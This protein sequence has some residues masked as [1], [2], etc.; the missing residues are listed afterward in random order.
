MLEAVCVILDKDNVPSAQTGRLGVVQAGEGFA[1]PQ[2]LT[3]R[4]FLCFLS[5]SAS[6]RRF[7]AVA[8]TVY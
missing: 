2:C 4:L 6:S 8:P 5:L 1:W 7:I 3:G